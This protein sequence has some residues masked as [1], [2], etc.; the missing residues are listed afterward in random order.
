MSTDGGKRSAHRFET[1]VADDF[2]HVSLLDYIEEELSVER[3]V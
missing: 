1:V 2:S 3:F